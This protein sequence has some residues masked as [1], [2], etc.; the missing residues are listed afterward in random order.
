MILIKSTT[1]LSLKSDM[2]RLDHKPFSVKGEASRNF[3]VILLSF[4]KTTTDQL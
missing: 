1:L 4:D 2:F 3:A